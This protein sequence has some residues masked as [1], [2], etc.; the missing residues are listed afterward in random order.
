MVMLIYTMLC[1]TL[2]RTLIWYERITIFPL[3]FLYGDEYVQ[4]VYWVPTSL[5]GQSIP[6]YISTC[7]VTLPYLSLTETMTSGCKMVLHHT[8][9]ELYV[10][11]WMTLSRCGLAGKEPLNGLHGCQIC[12]LVITHVGYPEGMRLLTW[13][14]HKTRVE[15]KN[16]CRICSSEQ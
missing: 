13:C 7:C 4:L 15:G 16:Y 11:S 8:M 3:E 2:L 14:L 1:T 6:S 9:V 5:M 12:L 10:T